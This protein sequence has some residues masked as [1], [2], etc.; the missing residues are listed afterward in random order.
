MEEEE[1]EEEGGG[2]G[3][4][5][6]RPAGVLIGL[7]GGAGA[8]KGLEMGW[9]MQEAAHMRPEIINMSVKHTPAGR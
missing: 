9:E 6:R 1:E 5:G 4:Q 3:S 2:R 8:G 7:P